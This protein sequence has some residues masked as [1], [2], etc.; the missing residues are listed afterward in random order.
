ME[1]LIYFE[2]IIGLFA[3][4]LGFGLSFWILGL[5]LD[6]SNNIGDSRGTSEDYKAFIH[7]TARKD[8]MYSEERKSFC[9]TYAVKIYDASAEPEGHEQVRRLSEEETDNPDA[10]AKRED[11]L[12]NPARKKG[13]WDDKTPTDDLSGVFRPI[14]ED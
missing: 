5:V 12:N 9:S 13:L 3:V 8:H 4:G 7:F 10:A 2:I 1:G 6:K 11:M 14:K